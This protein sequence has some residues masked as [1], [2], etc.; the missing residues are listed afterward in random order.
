MRQYPGGYA[1]HERYNGSG[2]TEVRGVSK[3]SKPPKPSKPSKLSYNEQRELAALP[4]RIDA[5]EKEIAA[6][7]ADLVAGK[8]YTSER[9][10]P[11][12]EELEQLVDRWAELE[13]RKGAGRKE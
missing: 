13:E 1:D 6:I 9:L 4:D 7:E 8:I 5:L 3:P 10:A 2:S 11:A 12:Q